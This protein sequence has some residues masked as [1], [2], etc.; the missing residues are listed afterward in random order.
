MSV[1]GSGVRVQT[2]FWGRV[3]CVTRGEPHKEEEVG[4]GPG[5]ARSVP[6]LT[7]SYSVLQCP[8]ASYSV[9][10]R[11]TMSYSVLSQN[12]R[13]ASLPAGFSFYCSATVTGC[14]YMQT[15]DLTILTVRLFSGRETAGHTHGL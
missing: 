9:L 7:V 12:I 11:P 15:K 4:N 1:W 8:A 2:G 10:Q 13:R 3:V 14:V 6:G 5:C